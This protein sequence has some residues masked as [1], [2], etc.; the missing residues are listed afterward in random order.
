MADY[1]ELT[2]AIQNVMPKID[3]K[4]LT[5]SLTALSSATA[6]LRVDWGK[7]AESMAVQLEPVTSMHR[8]K[9]YVNP[10]PAVKIGMP[11]SPITI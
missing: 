4:G 5:E 9:T 10:P 3:Y 11:T 2:K 6:K 7:I 8:Y 1:I